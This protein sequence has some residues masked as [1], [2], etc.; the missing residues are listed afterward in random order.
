MTF[1]FGSSH[2]AHP[3]ENYLSPEIQ[4]QI[5]MMGGSQF[6]LGSVA[7]GDSLRLEFTNGTSAD[8]M[9]AL[10]QQA[11]NAFEVLSTDVPLMPTN[12][13]VFINGA[14]HGGSAL[15]VGVLHRFSQVNWNMM[16]R[17]RP[18][19]E[20]LAAIDFDAKIA[21]GYSHFGRDTDGPYMRLIR[22]PLGQDTA[23]LAQ[24]RTKKKGTAAWVP[25]FLE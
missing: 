4:Q 25:H 22:W 3:G 21:Q 9:K 15:R 2:G 23:D 7:A 13:E 10:G 5:A 12:E 16:W 8:F 20:D 6:V 11:T 1:R 17:H 24:V 19:P 14:T 18:A